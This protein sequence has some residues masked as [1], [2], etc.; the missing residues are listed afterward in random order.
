MANIV[1]LIDS[2]PLFNGYLSGK[3]KK[4]FA[5]TTIKDRLPVIITRI[6]DNLS[7]CKDLI[8]KK[9]GSD[10]SEELKQIIG[11]LSELKSELMT[12]KPLKFFNSSSN[13]EDDVLK[14]NECIKGK[15][16]KD[17]NEPTW[18]HTVWLLS[19][20]YM[21]RRIAQILASTTTLST[22]DP[23]EKQKQD[24]F[25]ASMEMILVLTRYT[26]NILS[27]SKFHS[28]NDKKDGLFY[29]LKSCLWG[30]KCDLSLSKGMPLK[31]EDIIKQTNMNEENIL[32]DES[33]LVWDIL[34]QFQENMTNNIID[35]V[36]DNAGYELF[37]DFCIAAFLIEYNF[38]K[39]VRF[40]VKRIPWFVSDVTGQDF[41]WSINAMKNS[42]HTDLMK[43]GHLYSS[44][45]ED[46]K[47][48]V[49]IESFWTEPYD[50]SEMKIQSPKL[51]EKLSEATLVMFKGDL[52]YRK[53]LGDINW[54]YTTDLKTALR[55]F[56]PTNIVTLRTIKAD[57][58]VGLSHEKVDKLFSKQEDWM[59]TG[60][61][62]LIHV[63]LDD[64]ELRNN[65]K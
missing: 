51:Y 8:I 45:L 1:D 6:I 40:Y 64:N 39:K 31:F 42:T 27:K 21:Y 33:P 49:E 23:F 62:G 14:W 32:I 43:L 16:S 36:L 57:L 47:W 11:S 2:K 29:L 41:F 53:L 46:G 4:S 7:Q 18:Y 34:N 22:Y 52:N 5:Y 59:I 50:F 24:N 9:Y 19:E 61:Y 25:T 55:G 30:N 26:T 38:T 17:G 13:E 10:A 35:I 48:T 54:D 63:L 3:Y 60:Q 15:Q 20:C 65:S 12:N 58:I 28:L 37:S 56:Q 44:Y